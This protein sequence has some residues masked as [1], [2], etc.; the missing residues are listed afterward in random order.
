M[1]RVVTA[2]VIAAFLLAPLPSF[3]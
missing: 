1:K 3:A 2:T